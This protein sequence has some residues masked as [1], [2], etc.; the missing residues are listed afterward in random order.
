MNNYYARAGS[1]NVLLDRVHRQ[2]L[3][4]FYQVIIILSS[5]QYKRVIL[6]DQMH[7]RKAATF[8]EFSLSFTA[9]NK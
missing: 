3:L 2:M 9:L 8:V 4:S 5:W 6:M 1:E 7:L